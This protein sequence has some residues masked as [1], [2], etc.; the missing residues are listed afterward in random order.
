MDMDSR[1]L[2][3]R[4]G[5][6]PGRQLCSLAPRDRNTELRR[7]MAGH[8]RLVGAGGRAGIDS[9]RDTLPGA[10]GAGEA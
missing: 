9:Q 3:A 2:E 10:V 1:E 6:D 8:D 4:C 7:R 5:T